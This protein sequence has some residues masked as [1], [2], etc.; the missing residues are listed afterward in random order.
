MGS[1]VRRVE[2]SNRRGRVRIRLFGE[3]QRRQRYLIRQIEVDAD[4]LDDT[5]QSA[6]F[7]KGLGVPPTPN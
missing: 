6:E 2:I 7:L 5:L 1:K 4:D 3:A